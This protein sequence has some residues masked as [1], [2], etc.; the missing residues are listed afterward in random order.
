MNIT[1]EDVINSIKINMKIVKDAEPEK[2][3][4]IFTL[5]LFDFI[6]IKG[7]RILPSKYPNKRGDSLWVVP[8]GYRSRIGKFHGTFFCENKI[9]WDEIQEKVWQEYY[10]RAIEEEIKKDEDIPIF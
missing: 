2:E 3:K 5:S 8:P 9:I 7:F 6:Q 10:K 4:A 1:N